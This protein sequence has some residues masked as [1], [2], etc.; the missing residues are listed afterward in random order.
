MLI[1][2]VCLV[3]KE[4]KHH[5]FK[6]I[7]NKYFIYHHIN[8]VYFNFFVYINTILE[9]KKRRM[10]FKKKKTVNKDTGSR[11]EKNWSNVK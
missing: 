7:S 4:H 8:N 1:L 5:P 3:W 11:T 2:K 9:H 6:K 10:L